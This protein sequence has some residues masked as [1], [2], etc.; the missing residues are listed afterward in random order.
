VT[1]TAVN[2]GEQA[3]EPLTA[4]DFSMTTAPMSDDE[5]RQRRWVQV[6]KETFGQDQLAKPCSSIG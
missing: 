5:K 6:D 2:I 4:I 1:G 3:F